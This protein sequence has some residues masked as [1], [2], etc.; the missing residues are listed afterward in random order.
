M[1]SRETPNEYL[2]K[3]ELTRELASLGITRAQRQSIRFRDS[4]HNW[5]FDLWT[6]TWEGHIPEQA[7]PLLKAYCALKWIVIENPPDSRERDDAWRLISETMAASTYAIGESARSEQSKRAKK[8]RGKITEDGRTLSQMVENL[9]KQC[10][11]ETAK[12]LWPRL[13]GVLDEAGLDPK[14]ICEGSHGPS[15]QYRFYDGQKQLSF[16]RFE[17]ILSDARKKKI[18]LAGL[19]RVSPYSSG[20]AKHFEGVP[21]DGHEPDICG[22]LGS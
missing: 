4:N 3:H 6:F 22:R 11:E 1:K 18:L 17:C 14:E 10:P 7:D 16:H 12:E 8:P 13:W 19:A 2:E 21:G 15:Y 5:R 20:N 9:V